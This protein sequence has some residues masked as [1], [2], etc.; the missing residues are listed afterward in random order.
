MDSVIRE[1]AG[2]M[3]AAREA[4]K[5]DYDMHELT[6]CGYD[7]RCEAIRRVLSENGGGVADFDIRSQANSKELAKFIAGYPLYLM[8]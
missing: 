7:R 6:N 3:L 5:D 4:D 2:A 8:E 1:E